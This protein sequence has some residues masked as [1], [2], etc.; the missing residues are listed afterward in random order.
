MGPFSRGFRNWRWSQE[1]EEVCHVR[2]ASKEGLPVRG[3]RRK[4]TEVEGDRTLP[5]YINLAMNHRDG[6]EKDKKGV[7]KASVPR[8]DRNRRQLASFSN[9]QGPHLR[10]HQGKGLLRTYLTG[11]LHW[12]TRN[13]RRPSDSN[14][15]ALKSK[16]PIMID[17]G[18]FEKRAKDGSETDG[19]WG[20]DLRPASADPT[21]RSLL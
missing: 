10:P 15:L 19:E 3:I 5:I 1:F 9:R 7:W 21:F 13:R 20:Q 11:I 18:V 8:F 6:I 2:K 4:R 14:G 16:A 12:V 17:E